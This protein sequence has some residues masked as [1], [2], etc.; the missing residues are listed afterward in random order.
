MEVLHNTERISTVERNTS[1]PT[2]DHSRRLSDETAGIDS[3]YVSASL[4]GNPLK[5][6]KLSHLRHWG[7]PSE[8]FQSLPDLRHEVSRLQQ[9]FFLQPSY[10]RTCVHETQ[11]S[12]NFISLHV[13]NIDVCERIMNEKLERDSTP[14][15][16]QKLNSL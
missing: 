15:I 10:N 9:V 7:R 1:P 4:A 12:V 3:N 2:T 13:G 8:T 14:F 6:S 5:R 11:K 16:T